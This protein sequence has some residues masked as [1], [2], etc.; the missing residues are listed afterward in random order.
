MKQNI[1]NSILLAF[2]C[3]VCI[4]CN[5]QEEEELFNVRLSV[6][7]FEINTEEFKQQAETKDIHSAD[8]S[9]SIKYLTV[10]IFNQDGTKRTEITHSRHTQSTNNY[11][12]PN[13][14]SFHFLL[15]E[16]NYTF[17]AIGYW[18]ERYGHNLVTTSPT[19]AAFTGVVYECFGVAQNVTISRT[20]LNSISLT[21]SR[22][23]AAINLRSTD[24]QPSGF[25]S[26]RLSLNKGSKRFSPTTGF[27]L[28]NNGTSRTFS[29][30][31]NEGELLKVALYT[32]IQANNETAD[33]TF[34]LFGQQGTEL[35]ERTIPN[36]P[37]ERN[38]NTIASGRVFGSID[39]EFYIE[40]SWL[41]DTTI[42]F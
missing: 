21:L 9:K 27:A 5:K 6:N 7:D 24:T 35:I 2:L 26:I 4:A 1:L 28:D 38:R 20:D 30:I 29:R 34:T 40:T 42:T 11:Y 8:T 3:T 10:A 23:I 33:F 14:G 12:T 25:D 37:L 15:P 41:S 19:V 32:F 31:D 22:M 17:V 18:S 16:G 36:I 39:N 13:F